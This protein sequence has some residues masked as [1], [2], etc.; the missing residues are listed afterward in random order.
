MT[1]LAR[2][3]KWTAL[4]PALALAA[5]LAAAAPMGTSSGHAHFIQKSASAGTVQGGNV[6]FSGSRITVPVV[7]VAPGHP[8]RTFELHGKVNP[9]IVLP[10]GA[11]VRFRLADADHEMPHG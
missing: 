4:L 7:A 2:L 11:K 10:A 9:T 3:T 6:E 1:T 8:D 5:P